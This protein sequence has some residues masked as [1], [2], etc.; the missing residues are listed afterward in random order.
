MQITRL[1]F[2]F[3]FL[4]IIGEEEGKGERD[5]WGPAFLQAGAEGRGERGKTLRMPSLLGGK[6]PRRWRR[7]A[8][9]R[10]RERDSPS[11]LGGRE[12]LADDETPN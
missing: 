10:T 3:I 9:G 8:D 5:F 7:R 2:Q 4:V 1:D 12:Q 11:W 6:R